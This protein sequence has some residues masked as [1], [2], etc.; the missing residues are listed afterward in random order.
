VLKVRVLRVLKV[1]KVRRVPVL[2]VPRVAFVLSVLTLAFSTG[3]I[4]TR[5]I[6]PHTIS[7][8]T[9][10]TG[11]LSTLST[12]T[13]STLSTRTLSTLS[14]TPYAQSPTRLATTAEALVVAPVFFHG[15][16]IVV[17]RDV[18]AA[19]SL[20]RLANTAKPVF[21]FWRD[22]PGASRN[23]EVRGEF[24]DLGRLERADSRFSNI[25][26][27]PILDAASNGQ[28]PPRDQVF[29]ILG[30][31]AVDSPLPPEPTIRALAL[32][33]DRYVGKGVTVVGRFRGANLF[34]DLP[35][36]A[37]TKGRWDFV[38]QSADAAV[39]IS[40]VRPRGKGF[41]L[42]VHAR[43]DTGKWLQLA[44]TL[45]RD[46]PLPWI[47]A[48]SIAAAAAPTDTPIDVAVPPPPP[49]PVPQVVF[50]TPTSGETDADRAT[51]IR[52]QFSRDMDGK[53]F[54]DRVRLSYTGP[55]PASAPTTVPPFT[56]RYIE[57]SRGLEIKLSAPLDRYRGV[58]VDI[59]EGVLSAVDNQPLA[60]W[61]LTFV[62]G[63]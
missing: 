43:S 11:I 51:P 59:L 50:T 53:T 4:S 58:K 61:T 49:N 57:G 62:T 28:W 63:G 19:G 36:G 1:L 17:R 60:S 30:A 9:L 55:A 48:T 2:M 20:M 45:R 31:S 39:W 42:D 38:L 35:M 24:W 46:G 32:A 3:T 25:N 52:I 29:L 33:P 44:G 8:G 15:K 54:K 14:T 47:E 18:E 22:S 41:D 12:G 23:S 34:A 37:G 5:A 16:Q 56:A 21:V 27:Q 26:F 10:S 40:G 13:L 7:T 6:S